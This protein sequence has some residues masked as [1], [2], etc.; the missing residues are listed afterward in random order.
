MNRLKRFAPVALLVW[1]TAAPAGGIPVWD[2]VAMTNA[3]QE[4]ASMAE[5]LTA[6]KAQLQATEQQVA[7][8]TGARGLGGI[9][10]NPA[11]R[12]A[13]PA[14]AANLIDAA[15]ALSTRANALLADEAARPGGAAALARARQMA[16]TREASG[17]RAYEAGTARLGQIDVLMNA[18]N[19]TTDPKGIAE[20]QARIAVEQA[21]VATEAHRL[22][23]AA[24]AQA[25]AR[26]L[27]LETRAARGRALLGLGSKTMPS[28]GT[29]EGY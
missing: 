6:L 28:I 3:L 23:A 17:L 16:A 13:L 11:L 1:S 19:T 2:V 10:N 26:D 24:L 9:A 15:G 14:E 12:A 22:H 21:T 4:L 8:L 27:A 29:P 18:I 7:A 20:L 5:Q 25:A